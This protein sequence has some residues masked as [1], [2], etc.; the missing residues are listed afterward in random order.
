MKE[1]LKK[2]SSLIQAILFIVIGVI[3]FFV[4]K[5]PCPSQYLFGVSCPGCGMTRAFL[6]AFSG[7]IARSFM[8]HPF[9]I[10][11][12]PCVVV[13]FIL[14][15]KKKEKAFYIFTVSAIVVYIGVWVVRLIMGDPVV[16]F[17]LESGA[18][19]RLF[20]WAWTQLS[21]LLSFQFIKHKLG[22][23]GEAP[24]RKYRLPPR[25]KLS[26]QRLMRGYCIKVLPLIRNQSLLANSA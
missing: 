16:Q 7:D 12:I 24:R 19:Y 9:W 23:I 14:H 18:I 8:M 6:A 22:F 26:R 2:H 4:F 5:L 25:G 11:L 20:V 15:L 21:H 17:N 10:A 13:G 3:V 1:F